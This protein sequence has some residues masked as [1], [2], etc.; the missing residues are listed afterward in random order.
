[1]V[2]EPGDLV[3]GDADGVLAVPFDAVPVV[4]A[5]AEAKKAAE[6]RGTAAILTGTGDRGRVLRTPEG[7]GREVEEAS[8]GDG[9]RRT[10]CRALRGCFAA[11]HRRPMEEL[12]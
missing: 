2:I 4:L 10:P 11:A 5:A 3:L 12:A 9:Q 7:R 6:E 1:M 8:A